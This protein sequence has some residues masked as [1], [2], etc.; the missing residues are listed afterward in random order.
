[1][2]F[3]F[4]R[5]SVS[6]RANAALVVEG[7]W[8]LICLRM[9]SHVAKIGTLSSSS[10]SR[11]I[12]ESEA[13]VAGSELSFFLVGVGLAVPFFLSFCFGDAEF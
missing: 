3:E 7:R 8:V 9:S 2:T 12:E 6:S 11:W 10:P 1:M 13:A 5:S 4:G